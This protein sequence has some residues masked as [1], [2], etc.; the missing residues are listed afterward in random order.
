MMSPC[1]NYDKKF[2]ILLFTFVPLYS[3]IN[4]LSTLF[5]LKVLIDRTGYLFFIFLFSTR[6]YFVDMSIIIAVL[7]KIYWFGRIWSKIG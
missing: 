3:F 5:L 6:E 2:F 7:P 4:T 1:L